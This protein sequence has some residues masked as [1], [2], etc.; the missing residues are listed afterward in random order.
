MRLILYWILKLVAVGW[1]A[2]EMEKWWSTFLVI[3]GEMVIDSL[4]ISM[5]IE[6]LADH[7]KA[8]TTV[9]IQQDIEKYSIANFKASIKSFDEN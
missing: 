8:F 6:G 7:Y 2:R 5:L 3:A 4:L 9:I 1:R